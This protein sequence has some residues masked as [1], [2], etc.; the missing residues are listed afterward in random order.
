MVMNGKW[1]NGG[2]YSLLED[3]RIGV[4][5]GV[6]DFLL[7]SIWAHNAVLTLSRGL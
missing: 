4:R 2:P 7:G 1:Q 5:N 6:P 3:W